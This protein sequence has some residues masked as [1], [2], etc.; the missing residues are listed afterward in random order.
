MLYSIEQNDLDP[1]AVFSKWNTGTTEHRMHYDSAHTKTSANSGV[2]QR[3]LLSTCGFS[4]SIDPVLR[5]VLADICRQ[6]DLGANLFAYLDDLVPLGQASVSPS[7][8]CSHAGSHH[9][10]QP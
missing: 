3:C 4:A 8:I 5:H 9:I 1:A 7:N 6:R 2:D 10:S